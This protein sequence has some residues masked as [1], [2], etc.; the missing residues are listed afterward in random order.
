MGL[1]IKYDINEEN[2]DKEKVIISS[3]IPSSGTTINKDSTITVTLE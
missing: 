1:R 3:Q 2:L